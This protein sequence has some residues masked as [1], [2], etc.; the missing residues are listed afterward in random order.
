MRTLGPVLALLVVLA[1]VISSTLFTVDQRQN[2]IVFQLGEIKDVVQQPGLHFKWPMLQNVAHFDM[3]ILTYDDAE[4]LRF[5]TQGNRPVLVDSFVKWR[6]ND[7]R[8][9][10]VSV[11]GDEFRAATRIRQTVS[12]ALRDEF[13]VRSLHDVVSGEREQIMSQVRSKVDEDLKR[14]G[15]GVVDVR[16][17][18]VDLPAD[19]SESVY[20]RMEAERK[21]IANEQRSTGAADAEKIRAD[22]DRQREVLLAEAYRDAQRVRGE[23]DAKAAAI[24]AAAFNQNPEFFSFYRSMEAYRNTFRGR[25]DLLLVEP[26]SD[27]LRYF[28]D[29]LGK[30]AAPRR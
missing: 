16:L 2:A 30:G 8:Q 13:G 15:V 29:S 12:G 23:G 20:R 1:L 18:R 14:I 27:F 5:L 4:P 10:Y 9:Y 11:G 19:V 22:A 17:K 25:N 28:R 7:V 26:N 6:I 21:R 24:Y 3:R